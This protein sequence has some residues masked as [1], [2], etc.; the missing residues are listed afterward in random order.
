MLTTGAAALPAKLTQFNLKLAL[1]SICCLLLAI[2]YLLILT[3]YLLFAICFL[4]YVTCYLLLVICYSLSD[5]SYLKLA[6]SCK[7][8]IPFAPVVRLALV[9]LIKGSGRTLWL[10]AGDQD[11]FKKSWKSVHCFII[12]FLTIYFLGKIIWQLFAKM[13][14]PTEHCLTLEFCA[15]NPN[16]KKRELS[17]EISWETFQLR[18]VYLTSDWLLQVMHIRGHLGSDKSETRIP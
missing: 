15:K 18:W 17:C 6:T 5:T 16:K 3:C 8:L 2:F 14:H 10:I 12:T 11:G 4:L 9:L 7:N 1:C 13:G